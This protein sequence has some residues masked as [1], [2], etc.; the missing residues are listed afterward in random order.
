ML[1]RYVQLAEESKARAA[2]Q[3][4]LYRRQVI[5]LALETLI[6][7][8]EIRYQRSLPSFRDDKR[9]RQPLRWATGL[10]NVYVA[11]TFQFGLKNNPACC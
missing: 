11:E 1:H 10:Q 4:V 2:E 7:R 3:K 5:H 8:A 6:Q 9:G